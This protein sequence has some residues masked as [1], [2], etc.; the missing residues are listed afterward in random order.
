MG[1]TITV[2]NN[3]KTR[4]VVDEHSPNV[5]DL[6]KVLQV[7]SAKHDHMPVKKAVQQQ[8]L[9]E[10]PDALNFEMEFHR[11]FDMY[12]TDETCRVIKMSNWHRHCKGNGYCYEFYHYLGLR[13]DPHLNACKCRLSDDQLAL[14]QALVD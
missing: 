9:S 7:L 8:L 4:M 10:T 6:K 12:S 11:H 3:K 5:V 2:E 13:S 1:N 14:Y